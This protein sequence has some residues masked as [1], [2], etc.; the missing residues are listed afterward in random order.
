M[1]FALDLSAFAKKTDAR[2]ES[3]VRR[4][5]LDVAKSLIE[6]SPV[7]DASYWESPPPKG[8]V[9]G[10]FKGAWDYGYNTVPSAAYFSDYDGSKL[11]L[12]DDPAGSASE[13]RIM[14]GVGD[15]R[16]AGAVH[17][18]ANNVPYA[19]RLEEGHSRQAPMGMVSLTVIKFQ[20]IV[21]AAAKQLT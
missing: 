4:I 15:S 19:M 10:R 7:G 16:M 2:V 9:G 17:Y 3:I 18:I 1:T 14:N 6:M 13:S 20:A 5:V 12:L 11:G 8:Y 21:A